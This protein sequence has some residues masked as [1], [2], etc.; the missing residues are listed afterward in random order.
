ML[1]Q[2]NRVISVYNK[3]TSMRLTDIEWCILDEICF[4][5][6]LKRKILLEKISCCH[7]DCLKL[8]PAVRLFSLLYLYSRC[9]KKNEA[10]S[11]S[12][13]LENTLEKLL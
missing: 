8:T 9:K 4:S 2:M 10:F 3:K 1:K 11:Q 7:S 13:I 6:K 12:N 5:E